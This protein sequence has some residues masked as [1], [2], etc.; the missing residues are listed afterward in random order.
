MVTIYPGAGTRKWLFFLYSLTSVS[1]GAS[2]I[3]VMMLEDGLIDLEE[4]L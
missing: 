3:R 1:H 4:V 2:A